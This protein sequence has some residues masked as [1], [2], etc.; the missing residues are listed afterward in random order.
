MRYSYDNSAENPFNPN[1]PPRRVTAGNLA[2]E[3]MSHLWVQVLPRD[4]TNDRARLALQEALSRAKLRKDPADF[5]ANYNLGAVLNFE[6]KFDE[7][8]PFLERALESAP[9]DPTAH[10]T[11]GAALRGSGQ[12]DEA[13]AQFSEA[14][15]LAPGI[16]RR[17]LQSRRCAAFGRPDR[18]RN[19]A[20]SNGSRCGTRRCGGKGETVGGARA[21]GHDV[22][23]HNRMP[24]AL[25]AFEEARTL[26]PNDADLLTNLGAALARM[27]RY[28][29]AE[30]V[31][32][33]ALL[34]APDH[35][36]AQ[37]NLQL[38][39]KAIMK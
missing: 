28:A 15:K 22:G 25:A 17:P 37:E 19:R 33:R 8:I 5:S 21:A 13:I 39:R 9:G 26:A 18:R 30:T 36:V 23:K 14:L 34:L 16:P 27:G 31:L 7:A 2:T 1:Q 24:E 10:N 35:T 20:V 38:V 6:E 4:E 11:L 12:L 32:E 29:E 3:E